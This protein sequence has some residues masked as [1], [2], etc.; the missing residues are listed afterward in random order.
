LGRRSLWGDWD[1]QLIYRLDPISDPRWQEFLRLEPRASIFHSQGWL[2]A[3]HRS[4][5]YTPVVFTTTSPDRPL[6]NGAVF[7]VVKSWLISSRLVSLPFSDH[8][9]PLMGTER[10]LSDLLDELISRQK[11]GEWKK[12]EIRPPAVGPQHPHW[13]AFHDG[14]SFVL[15]RIDLRLG[16]EA[17]YSRFHLDSV[18]RKIRKAE[19]S[20]VQEDVGRSEHHLQQFFNLHAMTRRRKGLPPP[21][22]A[23]FRNVLDCLGESAK[24]RLALKDGRAIAAILTLRFKDTAVYKYGC[25]DHRY[26]NLGA[27]PFLLWKAMQEEYQSGAREFDLGRSEVDNHGLIQFKEKFGAQR[28]AFT[29]KIFP[30]DSPDFP[31][32]AKRMAWAKK[33]FRLLPEKALIYAGSWIYPHIG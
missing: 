22:Y 21:P 30:D 9:D 7:S 33:I 8:V 27:M 4:Y 3:I 23:W 17:V 10:E 13:G 14:Q 15:H 26:H 1:C 6:R 12:I 5:G 25:T 2:Q 29:Y 31:E 32:R 18:Q 24:I 28:T 20:S 19:R 11:L 16:L